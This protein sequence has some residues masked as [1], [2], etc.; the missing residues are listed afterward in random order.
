MKDFERLTQDQSSSYQANT[1]EKAQMS[2]TSPKSIGIVMK[3]HQVHNHQ[4]PER[5]STKRKHVNLNGENRLKFVGD[6]Q[7]RENFDEHIRRY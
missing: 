3:K 2:K 4:E 7:S 6:S 1:K 5:M